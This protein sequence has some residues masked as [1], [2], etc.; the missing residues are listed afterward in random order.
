MQLSEQEYNKFIFLY[1]WLLFSAAIY[2]EL[3]PET[4]TYEEYDTCSIDQ[5]FTFRNALLEDLEAIDVFIENNKLRLSE[6]DIA[7]M[8][9]F[10]HF[11]KDDFFIVKYLKKHTLFLGNKYVFGVHSLS[12][13][14]KEMFWGRT[15]VRVHAVL[16]PFKDKIIHDG[17]MQTYNVQFGAGIKR[18]LK[19]EATQKQAQYGIITSLPVGKSVAGKK[20]SD[21]EQLEIYMKNEDNRN[22]FWYDIVDLRD[23]NKELENHYF[24]LWAKIHARKKKKTLKEI[25]IKG[26]HFAMTDSTVLASAKTKKALET[27]LNL[28]V[29]KEN[30]P[31]VYIFKL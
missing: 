25:G 1:N 30:L 2:H 17:I 28:M 27:Q 13:N 24:Y 19:S 9:G 15:A 11:I 29:P 18:S 3:L 26:Y 16:L 7:I 6:E 22:R 10:K 31:A 23:K 4:T 5:K 21:K 20:M 8:Q 14:L 12:D